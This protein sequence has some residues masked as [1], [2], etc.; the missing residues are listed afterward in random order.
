MIRTL[1]S[2][3]FKAC[4]LAYFGIVGLAAA[5]LFTDMPRIFDFGTYW[6]FVAMFW[7]ASGGLGQ[8]VIVP[9][10][11]FVR[12]NY[13]DL[14][15]EFHYVPGMS[16]WSEKT[17]GKNSLMNQKYNSFA[18][19]KY[20]FSF[21]DRDNKDLRLVKSCLRS[22]MLYAFVFFLTLPLIGILYA[23]CGAAGCGL[24]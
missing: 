1:S 16:E 12:D 6:I 2:L 15:R 13:P 19:Y 8:L 10:M 22:S 24:K 18:M 14:W 4:W 23:I 21:R 11:H 3:Y 5:Q 17:F 7:A 20:A 9:H